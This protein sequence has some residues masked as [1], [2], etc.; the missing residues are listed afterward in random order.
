MITSISTGD[1][2]VIESNTIY[3]FKNDA[4]LE[5]DFKFGDFVFKIIFLFVDNKEIDGNKLE[6]QGN[7]NIIEFTCT[8]FNNVLGTGTTSP[9]E[10]AIIDNK[11]L[12]I[13]FWSFIHGNYDKKQ[14]VR[15]VD[16]TVFWER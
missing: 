4:D 6:Y 1:Y 11:K 14:Y 9:I 7:E 13:H 5:L 16:Y 8:N 3:L 15:K 2:N 10:I 12:Y